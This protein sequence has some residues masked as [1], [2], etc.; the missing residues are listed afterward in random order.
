MG[1][2]PDGSGQSGCMALPTDIAICNAVIDALGRPQALWLFG[3]VEAGRQR[4]DSDLNVA[5]LYPKTLDPLR[6]FDAAQSCSLLLG[7]EVDL[8]DVRAVSLPLQAEIVGSGRRLMADDVEATAWFAMLALSDYA[9]LNEER[10][11]V[12]R[13]LGIRA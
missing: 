10:A 8:I 9:R 4:P 3:S 11:P 1:S 2:T 12:L 6:C 13:A 7:Q 5:V